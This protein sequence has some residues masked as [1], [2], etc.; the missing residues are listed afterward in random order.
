MKTPA[1]IAAA[2]LSL[3]ACGKTP[4]EAA[5]DNNAAAIEASLVNQADALE[6]LANNAADADAAAAM[7]NAADRLKEQKESVEDA[8]EAAKGNAQTGRE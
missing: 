7:G 4:E 3:A 6:A 5:I 1:L 8:A 2:L